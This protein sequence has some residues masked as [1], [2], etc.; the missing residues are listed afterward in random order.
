[1]LRASCLLPSVPEG[2]AIGHL[3]RHDCPEHLGAQM[4]ADE[5]LRRGGTE[6]FPQT[7][8]PGPC[9]GLEEPAMAHCCV[10]CCVESGE[11]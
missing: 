1:M 5:E 10:S 7:L 4:Y 2:C 8:D 3:G 6:G 9:Q 11:E